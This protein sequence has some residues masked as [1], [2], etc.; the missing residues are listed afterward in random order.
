MAK[1][2]PAIIKLHLNRTVRKPLEEMYAPLS[3]MAAGIL[4]TQNMEK[5]EI[6]L[7]FVGRDKIRALNHI[8]LGR[9]MV[10]DVIAFDLSNGEK[11]ASRKKGRKTLV[12]DIYIC[13]PRAS[14]QAA[15][16]GVPE[17]EELA[18]LAA[19]GVLHVLGYDHR[20]SHE[21]R[22]MKMLQEEAVEKFRWWQRK[23]RSLKAD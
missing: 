6:S 19:H 3:K 12:G 20:N 21:S 16:H 7:T 11:T 14:K 22:R 8:Y 15:F 17:E 4:S 2:N 18:R 1:I 23:R 10:T 9:D 5:A 13:L